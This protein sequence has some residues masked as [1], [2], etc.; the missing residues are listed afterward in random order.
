L[1]LAPDSVAKSHVNLPPCP[2][3][4]RD[5]ALE[6]AAR[7]ARAMGRD[8]LARELDFAAA[9]K[10]WNAMRPFYGYTGRPHRATAQAGAV[11]TRAF[12]DTYVRGVEAVLDGRESSP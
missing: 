8:L 10:G 12:L 9:G 1:H 11:F 4:R 3:I 2:P 5:P 6:L 7:A